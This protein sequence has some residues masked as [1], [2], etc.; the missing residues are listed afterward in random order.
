MSG[1]KTRQLVNSW[2][3]SVRHM[4]DLPLSTHRNLLEPLSGVHAETMIFSRYVGFIQSL[5]KSSKVAVKFLVEQ[6]HQDTR[7][8]TGRNI[9]YILNKTNGTDIFSMNRQNLK[10]EH[11]FA[12][13]Q[14]EDEWRIQFIK[15]LT[16][17]KV[18]SLQLSSTDHDD[19]YEAEAQE[20]DDDPDNFTREEIEAILSYVCSS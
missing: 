4:W 11:K 6:I 18:G 16:N 5:R 8:I 2:S 14:P 13:L 20:D 12:S 15:E 7:T 17:L 19:D 9:R 10:H 1:D 3:V